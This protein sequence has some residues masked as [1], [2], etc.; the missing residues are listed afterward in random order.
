[1]GRLHSALVIGN[2]KSRTVEDIRAIKRNHNYLWTVGANNIYK[3]YSEVDYLAI[4]DWQ[5]IQEFT[6]SPNE[7]KFEQLILPSPKQ[8]KTI[9][10]NSGLLA[11]NYAIKELQVK[12]VGMIGFDYFINDGDNSY[13]YTRLNSYCDK[14]ICELRAKKFIDFMKNYKSVEFLIHFPIVEQNSLNSNLSFPSN[15]KFEWFNHV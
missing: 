14:E 9:F 8:R 12:Q 6:S 4:W 10:A 15:C 7:L 11:L 1:M 5:V 2:G 3:D 13:K